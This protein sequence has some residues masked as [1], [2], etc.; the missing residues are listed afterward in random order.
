MA[1][2]YHVEVHLALAHQRLQLPHVVI[3]VE[4][5]VF[6]VPLVNHP[7]PR[8]PAPYRHVRGKDVVVGAVVEPLFAVEARHH[9]YPLVVLIAVEHL[10]AKREERLRRHVVVFEHDA[11]VGHRERPLLRDILRRVA[12]IVALLVQPP[13][14]ALPVDVVHHLTALHDALHVALSPRAVLVKEQPRGAR[15]AHFVEHFLERVGAVEEQYQHRNVNL[16]RLFHIW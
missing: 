7:A 15:T 8:S 14:I 16:C 3:I 2:A 1:R 4:E 11:L 12:A 13:H 6:S 5:S 9:H 10:L